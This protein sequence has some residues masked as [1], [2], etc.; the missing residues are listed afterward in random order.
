MSLHNNPKYQTAELIESLKLHGLNHDKP[1][2]LADAFRTGWMAGR[3]ELMSALPMITANSLKWSEVREPND[4]MRYNHIV[5]ESLLGPITIEWENK[6]EHKSY[7]VY[8]GSRCINI[9]ITLAEAQ[10]AA[11]EYFL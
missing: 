11:R 8:L 4:V 2:Q 1:S 3:S 10:R 6:K 7:Y 9:C 5:A